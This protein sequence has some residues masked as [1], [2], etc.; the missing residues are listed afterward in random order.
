MYVKLPVVA[1]RVVAVTFPKIAVVMVPD[2][3]TRLVT[4]A[5]PKFA[6]VAL[7]VVVTRVLIVPDVAVMVFSVE[8]AV[9]VKYGTVI[10]K[11]G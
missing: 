3:A 11:A 2:P 8:F 1:V 7:V 9:T 10:A 4:A 6:F 5:V